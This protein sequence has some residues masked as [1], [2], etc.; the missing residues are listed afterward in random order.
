MTGIP[1][2][3]IGGATFRYAWIGDNGGHA[4]WSSG[5]MRVGRNCGAS[6]CWAMVGD[7][8]LGNT[9]PNLERAMFGAVMASRDRRAA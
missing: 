7:R 9:Y 1:D 6:T 2:F 4:E 5:N 3:T 8:T